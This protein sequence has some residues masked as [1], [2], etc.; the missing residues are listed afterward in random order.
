[1]RGD[2]NGPF[3]GR[4]RRV[5]DAVRIEKVVNFFIVDLYVGYPDRVFVLVVKLH[6]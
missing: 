5:G 2:G 6:L 1:M 3:G 4:W